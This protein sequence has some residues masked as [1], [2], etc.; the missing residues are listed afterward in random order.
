VPRDFVSDFVLK[1]EGILDVFQGF[2][3]QKL[4]RKSGHFAKREFLEVP[5][6]I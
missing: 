2:Y 1:T 4:E 3:K 6:H 5:K